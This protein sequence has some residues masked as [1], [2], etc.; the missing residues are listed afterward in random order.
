MPHYTLPLAVS[1][2]C[3][4]LSYVFMR[5]AYKKLGRT[6][7]KEFPFVADGGWQVVVGMLLATVALVAYV[8]LLAEI[9]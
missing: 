8:P 3:T 9:F 6:N 2:G 4:I 5:W 7:R 1:V